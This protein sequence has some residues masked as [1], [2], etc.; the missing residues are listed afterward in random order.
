MAEDDTR[1]PAQRYGTAEGVGGGQ[2]WSG[3][4]ADCD[5]DE[6]YGAGEIP[7]MVLVGP[8]GRVLLSTHTRGDLMPAIA[9]ALHD[10]Q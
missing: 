3:P 1:P 4:A 10:G 5:A 8:D 2:A 6:S 9:R 7:T